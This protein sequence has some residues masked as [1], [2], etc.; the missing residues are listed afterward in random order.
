M[1]DPGS[2]EQH[3]VFK[4]QL[5]ADLRTEVAMLR[6]QLARVG[7]QPLTLAVDT[8]AAAEVE[9]ARQVCIRPRLPCSAACCCSSIVLLQ[10]CQELYGHEEGCRRRRACRSLR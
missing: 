2:L 5:V 3:L 1:K 10:S 6:T 8:S 7:A 9:A 4:T